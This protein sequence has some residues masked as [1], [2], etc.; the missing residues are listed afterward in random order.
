MVNKKSKASEAD[1]LRI[2][3]LSD[4]RL[5]QPCLITTKRPV[6]KVKQGKSEVIKEITEHYLEFVYDQRQSIFDPMSG[7]VF[8]FTVYGGGTL[9]LD[10]NWQA[11]LELA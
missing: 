4:V 1:A 5:L 8:D 10:E 9:V 3:P 2:P 7:Q 11:V 6:D